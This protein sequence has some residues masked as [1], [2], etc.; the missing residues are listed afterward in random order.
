[1]RIA[2]CS[3]SERQLDLIDIGWVV[4]RNAYAKDVVSKEI[5]KGWWVNMS[6]SVQRQPWGAHIGTLCRNAQWYSYEHDMVLSGASLMALM[7]WPRNFVQSGF[8]NHDLQE[9][10]GEGFS[11][12]IAAL[13]V[14]VLYLN[15]WA[16][17]WH[18]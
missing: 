18:D 5:R 9:L 16:P 6:Q 17:W 10:A 13:C 4:R 12:P 1:M 3:P 11:V 15:P 8:G 14:Y 2:G 7:G